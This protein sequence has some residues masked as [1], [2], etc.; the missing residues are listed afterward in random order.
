MGGLQILVSQDGIHYNKYDLFQGSKPSKKVLKNLEK[1]YFK[2]PNGPL[3]TIETYTVEKEIL[4]AF[5][6]LKTSALI[7]F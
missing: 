1:N 6:A 2:S 3:I 4:K 7:L 5:V